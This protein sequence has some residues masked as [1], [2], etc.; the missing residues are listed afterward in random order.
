MASSKPFSTDSALFILS[1]ATT[2]LLA[3]AAACTLAQAQ[4]ATAPPAPSSPCPLLVNGSLPI[5]NL[6]QF[7]GQLQTLSLQSAA[8]CACIAFQRSAT[9]VRAILAIIGFTLPLDFVCT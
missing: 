7:I 5:A 8:S 1:T 9:T 4:P 2:L 3:L 6:T